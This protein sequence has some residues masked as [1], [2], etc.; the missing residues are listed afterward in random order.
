MYKAIEVELKGIAPLI[1]HNGRLA[2]P[3]DEFSKA[4]KQISGKRNKTDQDH[5]EMARIE[6][7]GG[8]YLD[9]SG[10]VVVPG[11]CIESMLVDAAKKLKLGQQAKAGII[12]DGLWPLIYSGPKSA[13][14]LWE[15]PHFRDMR[16]AK[17][18][19]A[20]VMR[21]RPIFREWSLKTTIHYLPDMLN[22]SQ[23]IDILKIAGRIVGLCD[24]R[25]KFGRFEVAA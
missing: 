23:V 9:N 19:R 2:N 25:P 18:Q 14:A 24:Y 12:C 22:E 10:R 1:L 16:K 21:C 13:D 8:L 5:E 4:L 11:E 20:S 3:L 17:I 6:F 7:M 15:N